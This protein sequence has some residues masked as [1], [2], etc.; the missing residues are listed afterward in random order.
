[1][2]N[3]PTVLDDLMAQ[4]PILKRNKEI[5]GYELLFRGMDAQKAQFSDG[6]LATSQV[7]VNLCIGITKIESQLRK[8]FFVNMTTELMYRMPFF[9]STMT[10]FTLKF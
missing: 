7:L 6:E 4:Q 10:R 2:I 1:M 8:P 9:Q 3:F 5:F